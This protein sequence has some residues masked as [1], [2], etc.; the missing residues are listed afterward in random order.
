MKLE[1][2]PKLGA[3][4]FALVFATTTLY[5][6]NRARARAPVSRDVQRKLDRWLE[7]RALSGLRVGV[8]VADLKS[9]ELIASHRAHEVLNPASGAKLVTT[10]AALKLLGPTHAWFTSFGLSGSSLQITGGGDP[11]LLPEEIGPIIDKVA[12]K[13]KAQQIGQVD[14]IRMDLSR[15]DSHQLPPA[16]AQ[17][18]TDAGYRP[19]IGAAGTSYGAIRVDVRPTRVGYP[20]EVSLNPATSIEIINEGVTSRGKKS[21]LTIE[22][23]PITGGWVRLLVRGELGVEHSPDW[24][25]RRIP[26]PNRL[27]AELVRDALTARGLADATTPMILHR[28]PPKNSQRKSPIELYRHPSDDLTK[29]VDDINTWSN[30]YMAEVVFKELG[31]APGHAASWE[32]A[33]PRITKTLADWGVSP[34]EMRVVNGSGLYRGTLI[35]TNAMTQLLVAVDKSADLATPFRESL[36]RPGRAGT[37]SG[38][39][40]SPAARD[41][42]WAKTGTL[43]E[44]VSLAG[45]IHTSGDHGLAF[46]IFINDA[47]ASRTGA[48]RSAIDR[49]VLTLSRL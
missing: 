35:S 36:A 21:S 40:K 20:V 32:R 1:R 42:V 10:A 4:V 31:K 12:K 13:L 37:L 38:R 3:L 19:A 45:Y 49:L 34:A 11:K 5:D 41:R 14:A 18:G 30:N 7:H 27:T 26:D 25:R 8:A 46:A 15:Y 16:Y 17:K 28:A 33:A 29:T 23:T 44:V 24:V 43:D 48:L 22:A 2:T 39:L 47:D 6:A 9:G